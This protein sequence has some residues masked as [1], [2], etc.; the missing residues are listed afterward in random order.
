M[1]D[2][3]IRVVY[4]E[5]SVRLDSPLFSKSFLNSINVNKTNTTPHTVIVAWVITAFRKSEIMR[6]WVNKTERK[7]NVTQRCTQKETDHDYH[8]WCDCITNENCCA[9]ISLARVLTKPRPPLWS[10]SAD[11]WTSS[12]I[13]HYSVERARRARA[14]RQEG[15]GNLVGKE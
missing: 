11:E 12:T 9:A 6:T 2:R 15:K 13:F 8:V 3:G 1:K 4:G 7:R 5:K 14:L 10:D